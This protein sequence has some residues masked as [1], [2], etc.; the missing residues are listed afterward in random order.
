MNAPLNFN[1]TPEHIRA[2]FD[3]ISER[4]YDFNLDEVCLWASGNLCAPFDFVRQMA[5]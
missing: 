3:R 5:A 2:E 1:A 4:G